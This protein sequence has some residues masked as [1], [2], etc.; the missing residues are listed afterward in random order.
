MI[1]HQA[2]HGY[3]QGHNRLASSY[4]L[5]AQDDDMM[6]MLSDW[7]EFSGSKDNSYITTYPLSDCQHYVVAKSWYADDM[8]RPGCVWTHSLIIDLTN[9]DEKF[10]FRLL[11]DIFKRPTKGEYSFYS[12]IIKYTPSASGSIYD[13]FQEDMLIWLYTNLINRDPNIRMLYQ[14]EHE[15]CYYQHLILLLLQYLPIG[16]LKNIAM[17]SGSAYGRKH[18]II[19]YNLQFAVSA[20]DSLS[21]IVRDSHTFIDGIC[22]GLRSIC[23]T[24]IRSGS[25]TSEA[26][27]I[28][29]NDIGDLPNRLCSVGLLLKYLDD[30]IA[31]ASDTPPFIHIL[32]L[33]KETFP[34]ITDG[35]SLK[36]T[37]CKKN[38]SNLFSS[39]SV[40]LKELVTEVAD[41]W[42]DYDIIDYMQR[43]TLL[44]EEEGLIE[45]VNFL[46]AL[47]NAKVLNETGKRILKES[48][49]YLNINDY[50]Y[51]AQNDWSLYMS[52]VVANPNILKYSFW[53]DFPE[54]RFVH[55]YDLFRKYCFCDFDAWDRLFIIVLYS[56]HIIDKT[57]MSCF[58][59]HVPNITFDVMEYLNTSNESNLEPVLCEYCKTKVSDILSW[60]KM[61]NYLTSSV[62]SFLI[63]FVDP[64]SKEVK[65]A[66][67][68]I[69]NVLCNCNHYTPPM[70]YVFLFIL[71]HNWSDANA[72]Q[73]IQHSFFHIHLMLS[74]SALSDYLWQKIEHYTASLVFYKEWDKCKKLRIGT[75]K[76]LKY[77]GYQKSTLQTL[78]KDEKLVQTLM[79]IWE[80]E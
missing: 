54:E 22:E 59:N 64:E 46:I 23:G 44:K 32:S 61:Q 5:S 75:V 73:F 60:V 55:T 76:Y 43:V 8:E 31:Q 42:I 50:Y 14:V 57:I 25:D 58:V 24:M 26:L 29:S 3:S 4:P 53:V 15:S 16:F 11:L 19:E 45:F 34:S 12:E 21:N 48:D 47:V 52:L 79:N 56:H 68:N 10:D 65:E 1:I 33:L 70:Y 37:F 67:S 7:S 13:M 20:K 63:N 40:V 69:W 77:T 80:E 17:C 41:E 6:K 51:I 2:L 27:R 71:G 49:K 30:I 9:L 28:F 35:V 38:I 36:A 78:T 39:E 74:K 18:S 66:G 62:I 72:L